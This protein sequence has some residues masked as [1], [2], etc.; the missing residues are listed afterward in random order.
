MYEMYACISCLSV[1]ECRPALGG[2]L[3]SAEP[4]K[5]ERIYTGRGV[6]VQLPDPSYFTFLA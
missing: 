1:F 5:H 2:G 6:K 4:I 3:Q